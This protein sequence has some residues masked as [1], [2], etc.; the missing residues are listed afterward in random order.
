MRAT[1]RIA[2]ATGAALA[3]AVTGFALAGDDAELFD[4][5]AVKELT[6]RIEA[7]TLDEQLALAPRAS[8]IVLRRLTA[9]PEAAWSGFSD[10]RGR[11][12]AGVTRLAEQSV[13]RGVG[14][15]FEGCYWSFTTRSHDWNRQP[16]LTFGSGGFDTRGAGG[17]FGLIAKLDA[18]D[19]RSVAETSVPDA[20]RASANEAFAASR[21]DRSRAGEN[22]AVGDV[23]ALRGVHWD[24]CDVLAA[25]QVIAKDGY[26][27]T[28]AWR[29]VR[30]YET[31]VRDRR[32]TTP[33]GET[34]PGE[35]GKGGGN[36]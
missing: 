17:D 13:L 15:H 5:P 8:A 36:R 6:A 9:V 3:A 19:L 16:H 12:D 21:R 26:G 23:Y 20:L 1:I 27:V 10:L 24:E 31:P 14:I 35:G 32:A 18:K 34:R 2:V 25:I 28:I 33:G 7:L 30:Q 22:P 11:T 4:T 29:I